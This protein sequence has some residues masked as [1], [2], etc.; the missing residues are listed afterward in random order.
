[1]GGAAACVETTF[2]YSLRERTLLLNGFNVRECDSNSS[3]GPLAAGGHSTGQTEWP[4]GRLLC[5]F[6][7]TA[8]GAALLRGKRTCELGSGLG[9]VGLVSAAV[10]GPK[11]SVLLTDGD[12]RCVA[13]ACANAQRNHKPGVDGNVSFAELRWGNRERDAA[14]LSA[15]GGCFDVIVG[16]DIVYEA[17]H[18]ADLFATVGRLLRRDGVFVLGFQ[19]RGVGLQAVV[20][21]AERCGMCVGTPPG[22]WVED[23]F[24][25]RREDL[26]D[27]DLWQMCVLQMRFTE[28]HRRDGGHGASSDATPDGGTER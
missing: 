17:A 15:H 9:L 8:D 26:V 20:A 24:G 21:A 13:R 25:G 16:G 10:A 28:R 5:D 23:L 6:L 11:G 19:R 7:Q 2:S 27:N 22:E 1:M 12:D 3:G 14:V 18:V 4:A